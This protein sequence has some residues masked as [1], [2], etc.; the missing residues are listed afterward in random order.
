[1]E[2][3]QDILN[4][5]INEAR[6][7]KN[8]ENEEVIQVMYNIYGD[9][10]NNPWYFGYSNQEQVG[11]QMVVWFPDLAYNNWA[12]IVVPF[13]KFDPKDLRKNLK[14]NLIK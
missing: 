12:K 7:S 11:K 8:Q 6:D 10:V 14:Y 13:E 3:L 2:N 5:S 9:P 1:M 4:N